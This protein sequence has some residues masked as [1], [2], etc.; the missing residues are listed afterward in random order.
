MTREATLMS[1]IFLS[2]F[3]EFSTADISCSH[4]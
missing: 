2:P 3:P 4:H 1:G